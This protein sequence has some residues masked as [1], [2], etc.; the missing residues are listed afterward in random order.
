MHPD[1]TGGRQRAAVDIGTNSVRLLVARVEEGKV[2]PLCRRL[3]TT[4]LGE[5]LEPGAPLRGAA[6]QRTLQALGGFARLMAGF[7]PEVVQAV[8]TSAVREA[9]NGAEFAAAA[10]RVL[11]APVRV[12]SGEEEARLSYLGA[13]WGLGLDRAVVVDIG[14]GSTELTYP[15]GDALVSRSCPVG[16]VR[17]TAARASRPDV[18]RALAPI[19]AGVPQDLPLVGVGGTVTTLAA[20]EMGLVPYDPDRVHG[21]RLSAPEV[22]RLYARLAGLDLAE[23][24]RVPGLQPERADIILAGTMILQVL[25]AYLGRPEI[26][27]SEADLL[28]ALVLAPELAA[29]AS[30]LS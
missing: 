6:R 11:G 26:V 12:I 30:A 25:L 9:G 8:A 28:Y 7:R 22:D 3:V 14:G 10:A 1:T 21:S 24:R 18:E 16:A 29:S 2:I 23:R 19:T 13:V 17:C 20:V 27:V 5:G 15:R 4:R